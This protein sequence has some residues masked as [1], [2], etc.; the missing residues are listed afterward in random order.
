MEAYRDEQWWTNSG[1]TI[2]SRSWLE[3]GWEVQEVHLKE[4][5]VLF[6]KVRNVAFKKNKRKTGETITAPFTPVPIHPLKRKTP[7]KTKASKLYARILNLERQRKTR[8]A[9]TRGLKG[10][11]MHE[12]KLFGSDQKP[13]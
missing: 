3:A 1:S 11:T 4:G 8:Y 10:K 6:K 5:F 2:H 9:T 13:Q 12:K 7:S